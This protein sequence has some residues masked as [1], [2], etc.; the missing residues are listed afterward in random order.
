MRESML[1]EIRETLPGRYVSQ[2]P[3][4]L[5]VHLKG[6]GRVQ[7][8]RNSLSEWSYLFPNDQIVFRMILH[9]KS[10]KPAEEQFLEINMCFYRI[11]KPKYL[12]HS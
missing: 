11:F 1:F 8:G 4:I 6:N 9:T 7:V 5:K 10:P 2:F 12:L 3:L